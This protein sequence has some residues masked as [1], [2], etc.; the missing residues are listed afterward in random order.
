MLRNLP[1]L[2]L[3]TWMAITGAAIA[4]KPF[5]KAVPVPNSIAAGLPGTPGVSLSPTIGRPRPLSPMIIGDYGE[6]RGKGG[7]GYGGG[8]ADEHHPPLSE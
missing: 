8:V 6:Y 7:A 4:L 2:P 3:P 1:L 5:W